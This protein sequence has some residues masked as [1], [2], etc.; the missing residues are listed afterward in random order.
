MQGEEPQHTG[1]GAG[2]VAVLQW[3]RFQQPN[4]LVAILMTL[5]C[6]VLRVCTVARAASAPIAMPC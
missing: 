1:N 2:V 5:R 4:I 6:K 3:E